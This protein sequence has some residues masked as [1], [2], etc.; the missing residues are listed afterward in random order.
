MYSSWLFYSIFLFLFGLYHHCL[1]VSNSYWINYFAEWIPK[2]PIRISRYSKNFNSFPRNKKFPVYSKYNW[3][4]SMFVLFALSCCCYCWIF[5]DCVAFCCIIHT[6]YSTLL[7]VLFSSHML[8]FTL[9]DSSWF[10]IFKHSG[11]LLVLVYACFLYLFFRRI[12]TRT[13]YYTH[14]HS[15]TETHLFFDDCCRHYWSSH[16]FWVRIVQSNYS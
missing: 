13:Y 5:Y 3:N 12:S 6:K 14:T 4:Q 15:L 7:Y 16:I 10:W 1:H 9:F 11:C 2:N 8:F